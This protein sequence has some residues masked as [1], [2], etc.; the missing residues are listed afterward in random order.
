MK[1]TPYCLP[2]TPSNLG[3]VKGILRELARLDFLADN[4][5]DTRYV[6]RE[7]T[8][9]VSARRIEYA[10]LK[11]DCYGGS[12]QQTCTDIFDRNDHFVDNF[13][14][15][16]EETMK[17]LI[18]PYPIKIVI[19]FDPYEWKGHEEIKAA[20]RLLSGGMNY[21]IRLEE[22]GF[23]Y[24]DIQPGDAVLMSPSRGLDALPLWT[25]GGMPLM[26]TDHY[27]YVNT[28][29]QRYEDVKRIVENAG[30]LVGDEREKLKEEI[31]SLRKELR[32]L[33]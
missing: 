31:E 13:I 30:L 19:R 33:D 12:Y 25:E 26:C 22:Q 32:E 23:Y 9:E 14:G 5:I 1:H 29:S 28:C 17:F 7:M 8:D 21:H 2:Q 15:N 10:T 20:C 27:P 4:Y 6:Y 24:I 16:A 11:D 18:P 3:A